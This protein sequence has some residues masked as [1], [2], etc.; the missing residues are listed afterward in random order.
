MIWFD[1]RGKSPPYLLIGVTL[2]AI[3]LFGCAGIRA[4]APATIASEVEHVAAAAPGQLA[5]FSPVLRVSRYRQRF[6][7]YNTVSYRLAASEAGTASGRIY[8]L[9][10]DAHYGGEPRHYDRAKFTDAASRRI[11]GLRHDIGRCQFFN[12]LYFGCLYRDRFYLDLS[13]SEL[14]RSQS[15]G[16]QLMLAS[17]SRDY[18]TLDLPA[19]FIRG[20]LAALK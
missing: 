3:F 4:Q 9:L 15:D 10:V 2:T 5:W 20:F 18:E 7:C 13:R 6:C 1:E 16:L 14:E 12:Q 8:R 19:N 11:G 17:E